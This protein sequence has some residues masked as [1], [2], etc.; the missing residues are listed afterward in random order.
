MTSIYN[1]LTCLLCYLPI[2]VLV[3][4]ELKCQVSEIF[5]HACRIIYL[6]HW[7]LKIHVIY[8]Q[9]SCVSAL[10]RHSGLKW[11]WNWAGKCIWFIWKNVFYLLQDDFAL[12]LMDMFVQK[13]EER[14]E[15]T[16]KLYQHKQKIPQTEVK[17]Q[18]SWQTDSK[19]TPHSPNRSEITNKLTDWL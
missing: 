11:T 5:L 12:P 4:P 17:S 16:A 13:L 10:Q 15:L 6:S 8:L 9:Y 19:Q 2:L 18:T 1:F 7:I 14:N 3:K